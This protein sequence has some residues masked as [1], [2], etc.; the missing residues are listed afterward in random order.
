MKYTEPKIKVEH[1]VRFSKKE[2]PFRRGYKP[3]FT[4][5][6]IEKNISINKET[7]NIYHQKSQKKISRQVL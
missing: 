3:Q 1:R 4:D 2:I 6:I 7:G 5:E